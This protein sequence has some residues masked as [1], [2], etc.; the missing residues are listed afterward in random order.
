MTNRCFSLSIIVVA[1]VLALAA[2][3]IHAGHEHV[4][5][6]ISFIDKLLPLLAVGALLKYIQKR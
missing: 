2:T 3:F 1:V 5:A 4:V 6:V